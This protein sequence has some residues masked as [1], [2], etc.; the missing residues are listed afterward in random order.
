M[1]PLLLSVVMAVLTTGIFAQESKRITTL[2]SK[3]D[4]VADQ[5]NC[6]SDWRGSTCDD[7]LWFFRKKA[8]KPF[9]SISLRVGD[10]PPI[11]GDFNFDGNEDVAICD[12]T[13]GGY[14]TSSYRV[15]LFSAS[16]GR[17][18]FSPSFTSLS[19][20]PYMGFFDVDKTKKTLTNEMRMGCCYFTKRKYDIHRGKPRLI[21]ERIQDESSAEQIWAVITTKKL[22]N[23]KWRTWTKREKIKPV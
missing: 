2:S 22:I 3:Y 12:G 4:L 7:T 5:S 19:Q 1:K 17:F 6:V 23:G 11:F 13:N 20:G 8:A 21:Y 15:Y 9:Q 10:E 16:K 14:V 18:V